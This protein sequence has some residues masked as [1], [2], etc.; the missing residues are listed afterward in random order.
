MPALTRAPPHAP[1]QDKILSFWEVTKAELADVKAQLR[2]QAREAED[3]AERAAD[4]LRVRADVVP[5]LFT[6]SW[7]AASGSGARCD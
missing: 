5:R 1:C 7:A 4:A 2:V 3:A 6:P